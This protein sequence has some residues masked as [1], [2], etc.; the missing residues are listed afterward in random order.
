MKRSWI[1]LYTEVPDDPKVQTLPDHL[2]K[3]WVNCLCLGGRNDGILPTFEQIAWMLRDTK[4]HVA[5]MMAE[6]VKADLIDQIE[7]GYMPHEWSTRQYESDVSNERVKR[8]RERHKKLLGN[9]ECNVTSGVTDNVPALS[10]ICSVSEEPKKPEKPISRGNGEWPNARDF[11]TSWNRHLKQRH[12]QPMQV[13]VQLLMGRSVT[14]DWKKLCELHPIYCDYWV[15]RG[16]DFCP[17][18]FLEWI[19]GGMLPPPPE[20]IAVSRKLPQPTG[21]AYQPYVDPYK[22][23]VGGNNGKK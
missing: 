9:G 11:T 2:F 4:E 3:F 20:A 18:T 16:W 21:E 12:D 1:R 15:K 19:D 17:L 5:E 7:G 23:L 13:V 6:L 8:H 14:V 22:H 10:L